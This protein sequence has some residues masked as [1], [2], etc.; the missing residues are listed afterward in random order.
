MPA[1]RLR[2]QRDCSAMA[3]RIAAMERLQAELLGAPPT[4]H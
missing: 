4:L 2:H 3:A 1:A